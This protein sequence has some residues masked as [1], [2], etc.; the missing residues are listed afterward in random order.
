[1]A[2]HVEQG[3]EGGGGGGERIQR[4]RRRVQV[5]GNESRETLMK[6]NEIFPLFSRFN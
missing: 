4:W 5:K 6:L 2:V 3:A 1:V